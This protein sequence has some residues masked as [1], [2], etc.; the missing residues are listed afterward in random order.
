MRANGFVNGRK[1]PS[2]RSHDPHAPYCVDTSNLEQTGLKFHY[3]NVPSWPPLAWAAKLTD[4]LSIV[5]VYY[6]S[7]VET[8]E[9]WFTEAVWDG[10]FSAGDFDKT[11]LVFGTGAR[12]RKERLCFVSSGTTVDR[13]H[14]YK[15]G[16]VNWVSNSLP[17]LLA[18]TNNALD[19]NYIN[20]AEHIGSINKGISKH[21]AS[22]PLISGCVRLTYFNNLLWNEGELIE[23][24][25][26][27][28]AREFNNYGDYRRFLSDALDWVFK[29]AKDSNRVKSFTPL[30]TLSSGYDSTAVT[31]L[32]AECGLRE[33][34]TIL[35]PR[36]GKED[37]GGTT[38]KVLKLR[39]IFVDR[40]KWRK[41]PKPEVP[42]IVGDG[43]GT[44]VVIKPAEAS[45]HG[46]VLL[47]GHAESVWFKDPPS[48]CEDI[49][50]TERSGLALTEYRLWA[51]FL[52]LPLPFVGCRQVRDI[53]K[54]SNSDEM[55]E[56]DVPEYSRPICRRIIEEAGIPR[57]SFATSKKMASV[58]FG[59]HG[60]GMSHDSRLDLYRWLSRGRRLSNVN[61]LAS[62][63]VRYLMDR[64]VVSINYLIRGLL[65]LAR[66]APSRAG[67]VLKRLAA[68][69]H[70]T[71]R[72][73]SLVIHAFPWAV[74][75]MSD[76]YREAWRDSSLFSEMTGSG[77]ASVT[78]QENIENGRREHE[79]L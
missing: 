40:E 48:L 27:S 57:G 50:R 32:A 1:G 73:K 49:V 7:W 62:L 28:P 55:L 8:A 29:N 31:V 59:E 42:F 71:S 13:L 25:K 52:H 36:Y 44:D 77:C 15:S 53:V 74:G 19:P 69:L 46:K 18:A 17:C 11:D 33:V 51:G 21:N 35:K 37:S 54:I 41:F 24:K 23:V 39:Q 75:D 5:D 10:A 67:H 63:R 61:E 68:S 70:R 2:V 6:G 22:L 76:R 72:E 60:E 58:I 12:I 45:L 66:R 9:K 56:W 64:H 26:P 3:V 20:Y 30:G 34:L 14:S 4:G 78:G 16:G 38:A 65:A 47:T 79:T 43:R